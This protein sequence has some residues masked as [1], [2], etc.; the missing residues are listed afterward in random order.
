MAANYKYE[1]TETIKFTIRG[2]LSDDG[3]II[4]YVNGDKEECEISLE[5]CFEN[6]RGGEIILALSNKTTE[7]LSE[8]E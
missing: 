2:E 5:K 7:D 8:E 6:F 4:H 1:K 3:K